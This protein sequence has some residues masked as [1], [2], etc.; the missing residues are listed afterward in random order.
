M[1]VPELE[2]SMGMEVYATSTEGIGGR[3]R[4]RTG[5]FVVREILEDGLRAGLEIA[6]GGQPSGR[7]SFLLC[8][9]AKEGLDTF[10][11]VRRLVRALGV[12]EGTVD[13]LGLKDAKALTY[14]FIT[15]RGVRPEVLRG[16]ELKGLRVIPVAF[17][18][19]PLS[20][21]Q[22]R[23]NEFSIIVRGLELSEPELKER[24]KSILGELK[25]LGG[26]PNFFG[27]QRF[28]TARPITHLVGR[29]LVK[30][31]V[32]KAVEV[33]LTHIGPGEGPRA[34]EARSYLADTWDFK[35]FL[36]LLP[37]N[38]YYERLIA[39]YLLRK[40]GN[41]H[42]ALRKIPLR[43]RRL[44]VQAYQAYL[45][46]RF[47]SR[48]LSED[49]PLSPI[50]GDFTLRLGDRT[51]L[52]LPLPGFKQ[53][54]SSGRQ[55]EIEIEILEEEGVCLEDFKV[56]VMPELASPGGLRLALAPLDLV[57]V[58]EVLD[59][60]LNPG[61]RALKLLFRLIKGS[62]ATV[63]LRELMKPLD[64]LKAGF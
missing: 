27:H 36:K 56:K 53:A 63:F 2:K 60:E 17:R 64:P 11:A 5:D 51:V 40:P 61:L 23:A 57:K 26:L 15:V 6:Q 24:L 50:K 47:L 46:N 52:A 39:G 29:E 32:K 38:L 12:P 22:L 8:V 25:E 54:L 37:K 20:P 35:G 33:L 3:I 34:R 19:E 14:Q 62:Y 44:F 18:T 21:D 16:L 7:G 10:E 4:V 43:L 28:G 42:R 13:F 30:G 59:D 9:L 48:R 45:F 58:P 49:L 1:E 31:D 41:Y 55:G